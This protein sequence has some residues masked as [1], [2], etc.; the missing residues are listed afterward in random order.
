MASQC[1]I[2]SDQLLTKCHIGCQGGDVEGCEVVTD[3]RLSDI[4]IYANLCKIYANCSLYMQICINVFH[5]YFYISEHQHVTTSQKLQ[6]RS[7][8]AGDHLNVRQKQP[9]HPFRKQFH[10]WE[11]QIVTEV[12]HIHVAGGLHWTAPEPQHR[13]GSVFTRTGP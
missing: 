4:Q 5:Q 3:I 12:L 8:T 6:Y 9:L 13:M 11:S 7:R 2:H 1:E 10:P